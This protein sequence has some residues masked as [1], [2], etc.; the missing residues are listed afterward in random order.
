[1]LFESNSTE[2]YSYSLRIVLSSTGTIRIR[3]EYLW[4][5][6]VFASNNAT[7]YSTNNESGRSGT[8]FGTFLNNCVAFGNQPSCQ[9]DKMF[10]LRRAFQNGVTC[11]IWTSNGKD[12]GPQGCDSNNGTIRIMAIIR[13]FVGAF[14][15][16]R[17]ASNSIES[18]SYSLRIRILPKTIIR[19]R[20]EY[21]WGH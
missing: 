5:L 8:K 3:F 14:S 11:S 6:F 21:L 7:R 1:M 20:F 13:R 4:P 19:I 17:F 18:Y 2:S 15:D 12:T 9:W 10:S 16:I